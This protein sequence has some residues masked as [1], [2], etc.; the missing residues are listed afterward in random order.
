MKTCKY[1]KYWQSP[2]E[3]Y[4]EP[5][6]MGNC[7]L[8]VDGAPSV[9]KVPSNSLVYGLVEGCVDVFDKRPD[10]EF[11]T[12]ENFGCIHFKKK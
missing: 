10:F 1:C 12:G 6:K 5:S 9:T 8:L 4:W 3:G 2:H 7:T 11:V